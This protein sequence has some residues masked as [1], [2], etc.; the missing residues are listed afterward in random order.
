MTSRR[1]FVER[2]L[3]EFCLHHGAG[4]TLLVHSSVLAVPCTRYKALRGQSAWRRSSLENYWQ[5]L[6]AW[7]LRQHTGGI[8]VKSYHVCLLSYW[9]SAQIHGK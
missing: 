2:L 9:I 7:R 3:L 6:G 1:Y 4:E 8:G 5:R